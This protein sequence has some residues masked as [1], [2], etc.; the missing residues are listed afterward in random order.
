MAQS[1]AFQNTNDGKN[2]IFSHLD[3]GVTM[4]TT[5]LGI[6]LATPV[7]EKF[8]LRTG[9]A[10]M[11]H[12]GVP[13]NFGIQVGDDPSTSAEKFERLS[14]S[15]ESMTGYK[16]DDKVQMIGRPCYYNFKLLVDFFPFHNKKWYVTTGFYLGSATIGKAV[17]TIEDMPSLLAV[18]IYNNMY[19]KVVNM[20]AF[21]IAGQ[22]IG[23]EPGSP[24]Y[25]A[26]LDY[27]R[28]GIQLGTYSHELPVRYQK[29]VYYDFDEY[30]DDNEIIH[31]AGDL[32][33]RAGDIVYDDE[34]NPVMHQV[35]EAYRMEPG[36]DGMVRAKAKVNRF[37][38]YL[39]FGYTNAIANS[40]GKYTFSFDCGLMFWGGTPDV[41]THDGT[42]LTKD[43]DHIGGKVGRYVDFVK[44][45]KAFPVVN[46]KIARRLY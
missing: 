25:N 35:G 11:P 40:N 16:V 29:N 41:Y 15:L 14:A 18:G 17:N 28:M 1:G 34:G 46:V 19:E 3:L 12:V 9:F 10:F 33:H 6:D 4:G 23:I 13:M 37:K 7:G 8:R 31:H 27:G 20:E 42:N 32:M 5:G 30:N 43:V 22:S 39:G 36:I 2:S 44:F 38:P 24:A 21:E 26:F 45:F